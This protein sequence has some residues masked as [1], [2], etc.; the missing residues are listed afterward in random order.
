VTGTRQIDVG[1]VRGPSIIVGYRDGV[2]VLELIGEHDAATVEGFASAIVNECA[3][4]RGVVVSFTET[5]SIDSAIVRELFAG[6]SR[7]LAIGR[8]LVLHFDRSMPCD[9]LLEMVSARD[10]FV[11]C[12]QLD[13]AVRFAA[14]D[15][16]R[17]LPADPFDGAPST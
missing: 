14:Q 15:D 11:C 13:E 12:D 5:D 4:R 17:R 6:D 1:D 10:H 8:R 9:R 3:H 2:S 16:H 7:M